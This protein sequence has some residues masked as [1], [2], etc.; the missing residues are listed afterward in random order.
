RSRPARSADP[1]AALS[2]K[3]APSEGL[4]LAPSP[5]R[6]TRYRARAT[7][8]GRISRFSRTITIR[9][10]GYRKIRLWLDACSAPAPYS[11]DGTSRH[12]EEKTYGRSD[13]SILPIA[14]EPGAPRRSAEAARFY[15]GAASASRRTDHLWHADLRAGRAR[16]RR[17]CIA[18]PL[19]EPVSGHGA[20]REAPR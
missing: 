2:A 9:R 10:V 3:A 19:Y 16:H 5:S 6:L 11:K 1:T 18:A 20:G 4:C 8:R 12:I 7:Y 15:P 14:Q 17:A 13:R